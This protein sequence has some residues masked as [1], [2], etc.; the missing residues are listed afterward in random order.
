MRLGEI[1]I[2]QSISET[3]AYYDCSSLFLDSGI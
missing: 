3:S 2:T 1:E